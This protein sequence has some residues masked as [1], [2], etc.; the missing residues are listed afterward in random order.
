MRDMISN[1]ERADIEE[2]EKTLQHKKEKYAVDQLLRPYKRGGLVVTYSGALDRYIIRIPTALQIDGQVKVTA[3]SETEVYHKAYVMLCKPATTLRGVFELAMQERDED[4]SLTDETQKRTRRDWAKYFD[5]STLADR[6][7][8]EIKT[9]EI[10][11]YLRT[12]S[13]NYAITR[14]AYTNIKSILNLTFDYAVSADIV[15]MNTSRQVH[16]KAKCKPQKEER[17]TDEQRETVLRYIEEHDKVTDSIYY[18]AIYLQ[19][20][21]GARVGEIK[22]L[23]WTDYDASK[24]TIYIGREVVTRN[25]K[26]VELE[27]TKSG[28]HGSREIPLAQSAIDLLERL[29]KTRTSM[30]IFQSEGGDFLST[31]KLNRVLERLSKW[32]GV[33]YMSSHK[34]RFWAVTSIAKA[35]G[36][37][38]AATGAFAGQHCKQTTLHYIRAIDE[39]ETIAKASRA[40]FGA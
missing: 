6:P 29:K 2:M 15:Q 3:A 5:G 17:Y 14:N 35:T 18:A 20:H 12:V 28:E 40:V 22:A 39:Q 21:T 8:G 19:F 4:P 16:V 33:P 30:L 11:K 1:R 23:R 37:D 10:A 25:G 9:S 32:T 26:Q 31:N 27:H 7:I 24:G 34:I 13:A 36:G 38:I